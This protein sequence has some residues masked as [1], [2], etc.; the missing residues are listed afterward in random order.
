MM[1]TAAALVTNE[2]VATE[3]GLHLYW[4]CA[5]CNK[6]SGVDDRDLCRPCLATIRELTHTRSLRADMV[7]FDGE[8]S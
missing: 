2:V 6:W 1:S 4:W 8:E 3:A 5:R 7:M